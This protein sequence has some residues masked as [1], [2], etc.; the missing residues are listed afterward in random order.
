MSSDT[1]NKD[2]FFWRDSGKDSWKQYQCNY[3]LH[4][5]YYCFELD[6]N[7]IKSLSLAWSIVKMIVAFDM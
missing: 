7:Q 1:L 2:K 3:N 4:Y 5:K 6:K